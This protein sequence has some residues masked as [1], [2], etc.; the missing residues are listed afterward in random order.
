MHRFTAIL[1]GGILTCSITLAQKVR[2]DY[3]HGADF[4]KYHTYTWGQAQVSSEIS[5]LMEQRIVAQ[6]DEN[7]AQRGLK[8]VETG[9]DLIV[10]YQAAVKQQLQLTTFG[11]GGG[12]GWGPRWGY[13]YGYGYGFGY[14]G[15]GISTTTE[16]EIPIGTIVVDL[17]DPQAKQ[18]IFRGTA[19]NSLSSK[20]EKNTKK[21]IKAM[22][23]MFEKYP[24][25]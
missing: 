13:G 14:G 8:R 23:K 3:D 6:I 20:P 5:Q 18:L 16:T 19:T 9:G 10:T 11:D 7:L 24:P 22:E 12:W 15:G 4:A 25:K 1:L 2:V 21:L 17:L